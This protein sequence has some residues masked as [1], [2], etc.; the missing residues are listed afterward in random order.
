[1]SFYAHFKNG[2]GRTWNEPVKVPNEVLDKIEEVQYF[3]ADGDEL[4]I[5]QKQYGY[6]HDQPIHAVREYS[7]PM[8]RQ[9][10]IKWYG[11]IGRTII[12][13]L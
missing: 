4:E 13:N 3:Q 7:I 2:S 6:H 8:P 9:R 11:D 12:L 1:M 10:V 5:L